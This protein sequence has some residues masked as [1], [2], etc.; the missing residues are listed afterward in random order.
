MIEEKLMIIMNMYERSRGVGHTHILI[1]NIKDPCIYMAYNMAMGKHII[2]DHENF[3]VLSLGNLESY[4]GQ[5]N[6]LP[7][8]WDNQAIYYLCADSY[9]RIKTLIRDVTHLENSLK[10]L[11]EETIKTK[12]T[13]DVMK[14]EI[15]KYQETIKKLRKKNRQLGLSNRKSRN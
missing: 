14:I 4:L 15:E 1:D 3:K 10:I 8:V 13:I 12:D 6:K 5:N 7:I 2:K 11:K 9:S